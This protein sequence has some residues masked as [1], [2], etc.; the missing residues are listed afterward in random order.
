MNLMDYTNGTGHLILSIVLILVGTAFVLVPYLDQSTR[1]IGVSI[2]ITVMG[3]W[4]IPQAA[5][6]TVDQM[7]KQVT[8]PLK[9]L[10]DQQNGGTSK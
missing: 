8:A 3:S 6:Q 1:G 7:N 4:F 9:Q 5:K 2:I 10:L